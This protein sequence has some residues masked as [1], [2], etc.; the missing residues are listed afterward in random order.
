MPRYKTFDEW[1]ETLT[2]LAAEYGEN[3]DTVAV[4]MNEYEAGISPEEAFFGVF[5]EYR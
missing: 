2:L 1:Y 5:P 4:W 3:I